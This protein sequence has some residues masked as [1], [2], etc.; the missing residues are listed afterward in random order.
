MEMTD[1][2]LAAVCAEGAGRL[3]MEIRRSATMHGTALGSAGDAISN[4]FLLRTLAEVQP[5]RPVLSEEAPDDLSRLGRPAVW[6]ID[7]LDGTREYGEN[8]DDFTV[9]VALAVHGDAR[10]GAVA[11]PAFGITYSTLAP[12]P[13]SHTSPRPIRIVVSRTRPPIFADRV[14]EALG[15]EITTMGSMGAKTMAVLRGD[16]DAYL[17][18]GGQF[19]WD[20]AAPAAVARSAGLHVSDLDGSPLRFNQRRLLQSGLLVCRPELAPTLLEALSTAR[21]SPA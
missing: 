18:A 8:R 7:P 9:H 11:L 12:P 14:A 6:I 15:G 21:S 1:G 5:G 4:D 13:L 20:S 10:I 3:L 19:E 17:H 2:K 16:A